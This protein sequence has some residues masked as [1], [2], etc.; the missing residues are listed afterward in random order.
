MHACHVMLVLLNISLQNGGFSLVPRV[1]LSGG[2]VVAYQ[3]D[4]ND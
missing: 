2:W 1:L 3:V 4:Q